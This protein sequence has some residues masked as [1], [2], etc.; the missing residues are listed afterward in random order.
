MSD[1]WEGVSA[2]TLMAFR[3]ADGWGVTVM[4]WRGEEDDPWMENDRW[5]GGKTTAEAL[6]KGVLRLPQEVA[7]TVGGPIT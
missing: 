3:E 4:C 7:L 6:G 5:S 2:V 1:A